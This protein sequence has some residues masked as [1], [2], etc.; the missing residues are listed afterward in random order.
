MVFSW[1]DNMV[2]IGTLV[3]IVH[4]AVD[5]WL[6]VSLKMVVFLKLIWKAQV[7]LWGNAGTSGLPVTSALGFKVGA[8]MCASSTEFAGSLDRWMWVQ[9]L[10]THWR[11]S[12][13]AANPP[14]PPL[15]L[16]IRYFCSFLISFLI[17]FFHLFDI[18]VYSSFTHFPL[19]LPCRML[20]TPVFEKHFRPCP[21]FGDDY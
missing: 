10:L 5:Y 18:D 4:D 16:S 13:M 2:R 17:S 11:P 7:L 8:L 21:P 3:L 9:H 6:E 1:S 12:L 14:P 19:V 15:H 20:R